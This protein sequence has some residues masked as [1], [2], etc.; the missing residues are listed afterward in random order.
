MPNDTQSTALK[1]DSAAAMIISNSRSLNYYSALLHI[2]VNTVFVD[3]W[4]IEVQLETPFILHITRENN[5]NFHDI[6]LWSDANG[7]GNW[8]LRKPNCHDSET[9]PL[10]HVNMLIE[11]RV[12]YAPKWTHREGSLH[13]SL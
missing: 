5:A 7:W 4:H 3:R 1:Q 2:N 9:Q 8:R 6:H 11:T 12:S 10:E 13:V